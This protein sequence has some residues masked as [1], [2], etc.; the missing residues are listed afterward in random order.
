ME[1]ILING[2]P[3]TSSP[4]A[5]M[6]TGTPELLSPGVFSV[7]DNVVIDR[8]LIR[9]RPGKRARLTT[10][11][12]TAIYECLPYINALGQEFVLFSSG[13]GIYRWQRGQNTVTL[14]SGS[15]TF[16]AAD[17]QMVRLD[18]FVFIA[19]ASGGNAGKLYR[20]RISTGAF[21]SAMGL[22]TP[23]RTLSVAGGNTVLANLPAFTWAAD[24][25]NNALTVPGWNF[26]NASTTGRGV[27]STLEDSPNQA[28]TVTAG[29]VEAT[30]ANYED[31]IYS[32]VKFLRLDEP[33]SAVRSYAAI[34]NP[35]KTNA[36]GVGATTRRP[37]HVSLS[38]RVYGQVDATC[39]ATIIA[40]SDSGG[41]AEIARQTRTFANTALVGG[42]NY[43]TATRL[44]SFADSVNDT[45][46]VSWRIELMA[47][48]NNRAGSDT[49]IYVTRVQLSTVTNNVAFTAS[50]ATVTVTVQQNP[51]DKDRVTL[52]D[53][54]LAVPVSSP[55][56]VK[57]FSGLQQI[58]IPF[59]W[60]QTVEEYQVLLGFREN[61]TTTA[62]YSA[63]LTLTTDAGKT[64]LTTDVS[65]IVGNL[66]TVRYVELYFTRDI[67]LAEARSDSNFPLFTV[68]ALLSAGNLT[69]DGAAYEYIY[70]EES[71]AG[72]ERVQSKA[73][74][75]SAGFS[76]TSV[77]AQG[78]LTVSGSVPENTSSKL[79]V[80]RRGGT[81]EDGLWRL[82][83]TFS[84]GADTSGTNWVWTSSS[85]LFQDNIPDGALTQAEVFYD[86]D[87]TPLNVRA[88]GVFG[89]RLAAGVV[90]RLYLSQIEYGA[91][92][93]LYW[94]LVND[95]TAANIAIQGFSVRLSGNDGAKG[96]DFIQ[97]IL[98]HETRLVILFRDSL[99]LFYGADPLS[100]ET[101]RFEGRNGCVAPRTATIAEGRLVWLA[102]DGI[103]AFDGTAIANISGAIERGLNPAS[104][105]IGPP[106]N[107]TAYAQAVLVAHGGRL[108]L[109]APKA[110][111]N[112]ISVCWCYDTRADVWT[113]L[114]LGT[115]SGAFAFYN[116]VCFADSGGQLYQL[117]PEWGD[118]AAAGGAV[119]AVP[120]VI[121]G[122]TI[123]TFAR[124]IH[125][126]RF[127]ANMECADDDAVATLKVIGDGDATAKMWSLDFTFGAGRADTC[128]LKVNG[129]VRGTGLIPRIEAETIQPFVLHRWQLMAAEGQLL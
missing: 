48:T 66:G 74:A 60:V 9:T 51:T 12:G 118:T 122:R 104:A 84:P 16:T 18:D 5:G 27:G 102:D 116:A 24:V 30:P 23:T 76:P 117:G 46:I 82:L 29:E 87:V 78:N 103:R 53:M 61:T 75:I 127:S 107:A 33:G 120:V 7:L 115:V 128:P 79:T 54:R 81:F 89:G 101:R 4:F 83:A 56:A 97:R 40:Y 106:L 126:E 100:F 6:D 65:D 2:V 113:R 111:E 55:V 129:N 36:N 58:A 94:N 42:L 15:V 108:F 37:V 17:V 70:V 49:G 44:F 123:T 93:G 119:T 85:R 109:T 95:P 72:L 52:G 121:Q 1:T 14:V 91:R 8:G 105:M 71:G 96:G 28:W 20:Y 45:E 69:V 99:H 21:E 39:E 88:L 80:Y 57:D 41:T 3:V 31:P 38:L 110:G 13:T 59:A 62:F 112:S 35:A 98:A 22:T 68:G 11:L 26:A 64:Y 43:Q 32:G 92:I 63:P 86:H 124:W 10:A 34:A 114:L 47:G 125:A 25:G 90:D 67:V 73:S 50:G 77:R 19:G